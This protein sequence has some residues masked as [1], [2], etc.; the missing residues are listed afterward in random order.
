MAV[1]VSRQLPR[2]SVALIDG[3]M[4]IRRAV[5][6][7]LRAGPFDVRAYA[8]GW[9]MLAEIELQTDCVVVRDTMTEIDGFEVLRR[10]RERGWRGPAILVTKTPSPGLAAAAACAGF[11]AVVDRPLVDDLMLN[12]VAA[13]TR[14]APEIAA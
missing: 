7:R 1:Q 4:D 10:L 2:L 5:Q 13:A 6:L 12:T 9:S 14:P 3:D 8:S 11:A